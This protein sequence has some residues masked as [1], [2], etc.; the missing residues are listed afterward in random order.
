[1]FAKGFIYIHIPI[2][3]HY[4]PYIIAHNNH[5]KSCR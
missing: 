3:K 2:N 4:N 5:N 1:M